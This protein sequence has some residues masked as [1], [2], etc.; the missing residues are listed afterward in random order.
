MDGVLPSEDFMEE[1]LASLRQEHEVCNCFLSICSF[2]SIF[3]RDE[4]RLVSFI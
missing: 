1:E 3:V 4:Q 2:F